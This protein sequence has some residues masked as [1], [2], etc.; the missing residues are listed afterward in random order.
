[1]RI[2]SFGEILWDVFGDERRIGGAPFNFA[3]HAAKLGVES[4]LVSCVG[5]DDDGKKALEECTRLGIKKDL[6]SVG[7]RYPTGRCEVTL[8]GSIPHYDII[9]NTA[10]DHILRII[11]GK[12]FDAL[13]MGTLA[14]RSPD[15]RRA[16]DHL[17]KSVPHTETFFYVNFRG[18]FYSKELVFSLLR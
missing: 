3:A 16:F 10:Y 1:M 15:S 14:M 2:I 8:N 12:S 13:Y 18:N 9:A 17:L 5:S 4:Y 7:R 6:I 11:P